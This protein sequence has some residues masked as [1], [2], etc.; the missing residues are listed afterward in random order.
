[1]PPKVK[2]I[3]TQP[4]VSYICFWILEKQYHAIISTMYRAEARGLPRRI[5]SSGFFRVD[6]RCRYG[7]LSRQTS[8]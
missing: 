8:E 3:M 6:R 7:Y 2:R 1:M 5:S 4:I